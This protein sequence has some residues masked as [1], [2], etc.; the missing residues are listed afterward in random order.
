[1]ERVRKRIFEHARRIIDSTLLSA[2][3]YNEMCG[4]DLVS[5]GTVEAQVASRGPSP[6]KT[7]GLKISAADDYYEVALAA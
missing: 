7:D 6:R 1:M 5:T 2:Y 4:G 3:H